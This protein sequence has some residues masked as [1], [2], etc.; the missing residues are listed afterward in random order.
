MGKTRIY[1][2]TMEPMPRDNLQVLQQQRTI[3]PPNT[4]SDELIEARVSSKD[5]NNDTSLSRKGK[6]NS[7]AG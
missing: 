3:T 2:N 6:V 5:T 4:G 1:S 7:K